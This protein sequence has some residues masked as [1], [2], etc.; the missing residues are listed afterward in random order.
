MNI[1]DEQLL[2][3]S[4]SDGHFFSDKSVIS[5]AWKILVELVWVKRAL[6]NKSS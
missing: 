2:T 4:T 6:D 1:L 5:C 3:G